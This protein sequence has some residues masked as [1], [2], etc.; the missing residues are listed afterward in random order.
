MQIEKLGQRTWPLE[1]EG[2]TLRIGGVELDL[3]ALS[4]QGLEYILVYAHGGEPR[5]EPSSWIGA[6]VVL[7]PREWEVKSVLVEGFEGEVAA[8]ELRPKPLNLE[9]VRVRL[10]GLG[11]EA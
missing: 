11:G 6:E 4:A 3:E 9:L 5:L 8:S 10:F 2:N 7:P 1:L